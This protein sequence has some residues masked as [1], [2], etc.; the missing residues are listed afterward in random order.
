MELSRADLR[1][2]AR[3]ATESLGAPDLGVVL[4][5]GFGGLPGWLDVDASLP[6][7]EIPGYP[8]GA[9]DGHDGTIV[10]ASLAGARL[11]LCCGRLHLYE[12]FDAAEVAFPVSLLA[13]AGAR[14]LLLTCAA[15]GLDERHVPGDLVLV[16]DHLNLTGTDPVRAIAVARRRPA[17]PDLQ[18]LYDPALRER[19]RA[20]AGETGV[21]LREGVL[22][23]VGGP[24]FETPAEVRMLRRLG[25]DV[26]SMSV[27]PEA[28]AA[29]YHGLRT[30]ALACV[31]NPGAGLGGAATIDHDA[32]LEQVERA[33]AGRRELFLA[34]LRG[35]L[36]ELG[37]PTATR[38]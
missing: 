18:G 1:A 26:V 5:S 12:G 20:T 24:C 37:A 4:G 28:I 34:G 31:A 22:A 32:V 30:A 16:T 38:L 8:R 14:G 7:R 17:F 35:M 27:V 15:G 19:W 6:C 2:A 10:A 29:R 21:E 13:A 11:W 9:V 23:A 36:A 3:R 33:V 25:A